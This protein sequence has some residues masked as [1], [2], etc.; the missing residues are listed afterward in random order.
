MEIRDLRVIR[1]GTFEAEAAARELRKAGRPITL[2]D[3]P[4][5]LLMLL[6]EHPGQLVTRDELRQKLW[7]ETGVIVDG[8]LC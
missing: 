5:R 3:Q 7:G 4:F 6:L 8:F 2:Q 1:V